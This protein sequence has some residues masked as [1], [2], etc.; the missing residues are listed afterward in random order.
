MA[1]NSE[2]RFSRIDGSSVDLPEVDNDGN[3]P[4][5]MLEIGS[6]VDPL[7]EMAE[8]I[9]AGGRVILK[10][11]GRI[12]GIVAPIDLSELVKNYIENNSELVTQL[13]DQLAHP[14]NWTPAREVFG[15]DFPA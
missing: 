15:R 10:Q 11:S 9:Q 5:A 1:S 6:E 8:I 12:F 14:D 4:F 7:N 13:E 3:S 2:V